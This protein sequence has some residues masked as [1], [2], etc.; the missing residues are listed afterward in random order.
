MKRTLEN[1]MDLFRK[2]KN[3][4]ILA[5]VVLILVIGPALVKSQDVGTGSATAN[6]LAVLAVSS[7]HDLTFI[8]VMQ[9]VP[10]TAD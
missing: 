4:G 10:K 2:I 7:T 9:G 3:A 8:D 1:K 5:T 6:V